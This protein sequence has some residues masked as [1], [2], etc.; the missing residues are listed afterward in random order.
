MIA[1]E[2]HRIM[3]LSFVT[4]AELEV[5]LSDVGHVIRKNN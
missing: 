1:S 2:I 5:K 4:N 3:L